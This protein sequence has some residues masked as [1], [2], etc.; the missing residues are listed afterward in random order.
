[1][2]GLS[3][4]GKTGTKKEGLPDGSDDSGPIRDVLLEDDVEH[5][6]GGVFTFGV[7]VPVFV[8]GQPEL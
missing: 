6:L 1:M 8:D 2:E 4:K 3:H 7:E 5:L